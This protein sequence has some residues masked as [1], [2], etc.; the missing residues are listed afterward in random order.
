MCAR[1]SLFKHAWTC[2]LLGGLCQAVSCLHRN[3]TSLLINCL[4]VY[5]SIIKQEFVRKRRT[6]GT[7][8]AAVT[9]VCLI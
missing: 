1:G 5:T 7:A 2:R 8:T 4:V 6:P 3:A 9:Q